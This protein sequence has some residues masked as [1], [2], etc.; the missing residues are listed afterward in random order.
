MIQVAA[1][2]PPSSW[3]QLVFWREGEHRC[4]LWMATGI[5]EL[6]IYVEDKLLYKEHAPLEALY[7]RAEQLRAQMGEGPPLE[8]GP[9]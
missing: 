1:M 2:S 9:S 3:P 6:R 5:P 8:H 7:D 4:E